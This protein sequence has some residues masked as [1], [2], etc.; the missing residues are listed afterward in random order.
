MTVVSVWMVGL[1]RKPRGKWYFCALSGMQRIRLFHSLL[2]TCIQ[3][4]DVNNVYYIIL[5]DKS[6]MQPYRHNLFNKGCFTSIIA[7]QS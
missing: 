7:F 6:I 1:E 4:A 5:G 3:F 2:Y